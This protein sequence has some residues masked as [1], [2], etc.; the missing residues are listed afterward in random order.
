MALFILIAVPTVL[1]II[2]YFVIKDGNEQL[3]DFFKDE[4]IDDPTIT[5]WDDNKTHTEGKI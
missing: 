2:S 5:C 3:D 4:E 1:L